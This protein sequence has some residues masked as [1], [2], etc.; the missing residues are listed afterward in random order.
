MLGELLRQLAANHHADQG[1]LVGLLHRQGA[2]VLTISQYG[3]ALAYPRHFHQAVGDVD[4]ADAAGP[5]LGDN[6][7]QALPLDIREGRCRFVQEED[8][9]PLGDD[10]G[11]LRQLLLGDAQAAH[12]DAGVDVHA[13][14][15]QGLFPPLVHGGPIHHADAIARRLTEEDVLGH[16][17]AGYQA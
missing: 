9:R 1:I 14:F 16:A 7:K 17:E 3:D 13:Q 4:D 11:D 15:D 6:I 2:D 5:Q 8:A 10:A 12:F